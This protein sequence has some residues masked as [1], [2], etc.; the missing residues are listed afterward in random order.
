MSEAQ[1][2][3]QHRQE[4]IS[5]HQLNMGDNQQ[6]SGGNSREGGHSR[7]APLAMKGVPTHTTNE[8]PGKAKQQNLTKVI[9]DYIVSMSVK[10]L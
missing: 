10:L 6:H 8:R 1:T 9:T 5:K 3:V 2:S 4:T 7:E